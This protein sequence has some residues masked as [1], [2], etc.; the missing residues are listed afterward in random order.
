[1]VGRMVWAASAG[2]RICYE[3]GRKARD[4]E[5]KPWTT[6]ICAHLDKIDRARPKTGSTLT[7]L[8]TMGPNPIFSTTKT[9]N[10]ST[11]YEP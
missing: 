10:G 9:Q 3:A 7:Q 1:M 2:I 6:I 5:I 4:A 11:N 8:V